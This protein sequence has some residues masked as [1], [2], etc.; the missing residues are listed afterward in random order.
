MITTPTNSSCFLVPSARQILFGVDWMSQ[1]TD[2]VLLASDTFLACDKN[3]I[4]NRE[5]LKFRILRLVIP[6]RKLH[7]NL[8][9]LTFDL[10]EV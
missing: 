1:L 2:P 5:K 3:K 4:I 6:P 8:N 10:T 9:C 7:E